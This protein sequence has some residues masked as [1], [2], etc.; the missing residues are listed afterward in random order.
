MNAATIAY[1]Q[2]Q[3]FR[4]KGEAQSASSHYVT[5]KCLEPRT[6]APAQRKRLG[7]ARKISISNQENV[8]KVLR[9]KIFIIYV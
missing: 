1:V 4:E 3:L 8:G 7:Y 2:M 9:S 6:D 5:P